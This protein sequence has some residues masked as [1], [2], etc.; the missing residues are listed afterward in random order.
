MYH[1]LGRKLVFFIIAINLFGT[2]YSLLF[3]VMAARSMRVGV[4]IG[5]P[6]ALLIE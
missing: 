3:E 5:S 6:L 4:S 1:A 2:N